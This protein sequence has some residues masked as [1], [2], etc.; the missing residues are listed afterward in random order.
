MKGEQ[1]GPKKG[2]G[3]KGVIFIPK[4]TLITVKLDN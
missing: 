3:F 1:G 2:L 4:T